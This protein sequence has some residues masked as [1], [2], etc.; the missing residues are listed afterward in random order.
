MSANDDWDSHEVY[1]SLAL[2]AL[3]LSV[4]AVLFSRKRGAPPAAVDR[5]LV[6]K[7]FVVTG[8][9][10]GIGKAIAAA[11]VARGGRV[12][13]GCRDLTAGAASRADILLSHPEAEP[14][15]TW[16]WRT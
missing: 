11:L 16:R 8:A 3:G 7:S 9:N 13:L 5:D 1:A 6:G 12:I 10:V 15:H 14:S 2:G 4:G